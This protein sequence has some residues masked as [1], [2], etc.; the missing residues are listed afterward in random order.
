MRYATTRFA[1]IDVPDDKILHFPLGLAGFEQEKRF[2]ILKHRPDSS[3]FWLQSLATPELAFSMLFPFSF[4]P[5]YRPRLARSDL[6]ILK[7]QSP[8]DLEFYCMVVIPKDPSRMTINLLSPVV[9]HSASQRGL[10]A[11]LSET[12]YR[13]DHRLI[14]GSE[15]NDADNPAR[16]G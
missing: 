2:V 1:E 9:V 6:K 7:A 15:S 5:D 12:E 11:V 10:Q 13:V 16:A 14:A 3:F 4:V 8:G